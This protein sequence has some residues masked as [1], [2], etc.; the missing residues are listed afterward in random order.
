[1]L[2]LVV[3]DIPRTV[4]YISLKKNCFN[5]FCNTCD[6]NVFVYYSFPTIKNM[7]IHTIFSGSTINIASAS[8]CSRHLDVKK[9]QP[10]CVT[11]LRSAIW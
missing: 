8:S 9:W 4:L 3:P 6:G 5:I 1:M 10:E 7:Y 11:I 2:V